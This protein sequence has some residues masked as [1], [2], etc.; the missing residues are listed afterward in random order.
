RV[1][2][3]RVST[4]SGRRWSGRSPGTAW[5][6][7]WYWTGRRRPDTAPWRQSMR[8]SGIGLPRPW[9]RWAR[10]RPMSGNEMH[11]NVSWS[12][13]G[14]IGSAPELREPVIA[15]SLGGLRW[16]IESLLMPDDAVE[17]RFHLDK[18]AARE[19]DRRR[20]GGSGTLDR[21]VR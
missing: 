16:K 10:A 7:L 14:F 4:R 13:R 5:N 1:Y 6:T 18:Q 8:R 15:L 9:R 20:W 19:R 11:V 17:L 2:A 3:P 12:A 21:P